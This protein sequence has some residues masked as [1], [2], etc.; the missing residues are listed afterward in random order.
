MSLLVRAALQVIMRLFYFRKRR[1][2][3]D[4]DEETSKTLLRSKNGSI[5]RGDKPKDLVELHRIAHPTNGM[6]SHPPIPVE[7]FAE[8]LSA[9]KANV[10][11]EF[12][13]EFE[14]KG[15]LTLNKIFP[16]SDRFRICR[17]QSFCL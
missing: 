10:Y 5:S 12:F 11:E 14:V 15:F 17:V 7:N 8:H 6:M 3:L 13:K 1:Q 2:R 16:I 9:L 4:Q